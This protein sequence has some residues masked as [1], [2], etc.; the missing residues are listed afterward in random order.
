[1]P[2]LAESPELVGFFSYSRDD[3]EDFDRTLSS[4]RQ[5]IGKELRA[6]LGRTKQDFRLWQDQDAIAP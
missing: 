5:A 4:L 3:D 2:T 6:E 1:M